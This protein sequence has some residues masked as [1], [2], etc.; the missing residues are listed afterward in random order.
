MIKHVVEAAT[1][2]PGYQSKI[3]CWLTTAGDF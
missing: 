2:D 3:S 1:H